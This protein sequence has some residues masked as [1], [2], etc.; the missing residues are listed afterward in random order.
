[1]LAAARACG[2]QKTKEQTCS[3]GLNYRL[4]WC[5]SWK[6][7][8]CGLPGDETENA[9]AALSSCSEAGANKAAAS[10]FA[11]TAVVPSCAALG[12]AAVGA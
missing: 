9:F 8:L 10:G 2:Q 1:M 11:V 4:W 12:V 5:S 6:S 3:L 7:R